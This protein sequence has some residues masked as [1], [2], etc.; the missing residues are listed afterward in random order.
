M[1]E[2]VQVGVL[3]CLNCDPNRWVFEVAV[4]VV[5]VAGGLVMS[6]WRDLPL[7][8]IITFAAL[9][10]AE[11]IRLVISEQRLVLEAAPEIF[12]VPNMLLW[13]AYFLLIAVI[14]HIVQRAALMLTNLR[15]QQG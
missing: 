8:A 6:R 12:E 5:A 11:V 4:V 15:G 7:V 3:Y 10:V 2:P 1:E 9:W 14:A 13:F